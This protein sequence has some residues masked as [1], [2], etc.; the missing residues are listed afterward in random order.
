[1]CNKTILT[2]YIYLKYCTTQVIIIPLA[3]VERQLKS[4]VWKQIIELSGGHPLPLLIHNIKSAFGDIVSSHII[5]HGFDD[6]I[7]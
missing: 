4:W 7:R 2:F 6:R 3:L 5:K 1:M